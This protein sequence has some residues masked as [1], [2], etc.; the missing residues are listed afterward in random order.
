MKD[1]KEVFLPCLISILLA[2]FLMMG[3]LAVQPALIAAAESNGIL[4]GFWP[5]WLENVMA[6]SVFYRIMWLIG[7]WTEGA[8]LKSVPAAIFMLI[9]ALVA[10][11]LEKK[12]SKY[13]GTGVGGNCGVF[14]QLLSAQLLGL[15]ICQLVYGRFFAVAGWIPTFTPMCS[16]APALILTFGKEPK[17]VVTSAL[18]AGLVPF[19]I[20]YFIMRCMTDPVGVPGFIAGALGMAIGT[21]ICTEICRML[22]WMKKETEEKPPVDAQAAENCEEV[23]A[24]PATSGTKLL[25]RRLFADSNELVFWGSSISGLAMY[26]GATVSWLLNP[27]HPSYSSGKFPIMMCAHFCS[28]ALAFFLY[29]PRYK[30]NGFAFTFPCIV[31]TAA[32]VNTYPA[33]WQIVVPTIIVGAIILPFVVEWILGFIKYDGRWH[34]CVFAL[35]TIAISCLFWSFFVMNILMPAFAPVAG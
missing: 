30:K 12:K 24:A 32:I 26:V 11:G 31:F 23:P 6:G 10:F 7:D 2:V 13:A 28:V 15:V 21:I 17:K 8:F 22:P 33:V 27:L 3:M 18:L 5:T 35:S 29:Y 20:A 16:V 34:V 9:A 4:F 25:V 19:P 14:P 1:R